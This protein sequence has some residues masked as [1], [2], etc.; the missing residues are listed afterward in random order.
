MSEELR[1][2]VE[3]HRALA[4]YYDTALDCTFELGG[5]QCEA[6]EVFHKDM[7]LP[8]IVE[9]ASEYRKRAFGR[10]L[11]AEIVAYDKGLLGKTVHFPLNDDWTALM[12]LV[13]ASEL[14]FRPEPG[15][16]IDLHPIFEYCW[17]PPEHRARAS[18]RPTFV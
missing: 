13:R 18:W 10:D 7:F 16:V 12:L 11:A 9:V 6:G 3:P 15:R 5:Q 8:L 17:L 1:I 4:R 14:V 2:P